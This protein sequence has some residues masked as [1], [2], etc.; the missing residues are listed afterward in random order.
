MSSKSQKLTSLALLLLF[1]TVTVSID[2]FHTDRGALRDTSCPVCHFQNSSIAIA[3]DVCIEMPDLVLLE[4]LDD[5]VFS[6]YK[7]FS[8]RSIAARSPPL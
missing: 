1:V 4:I 3:Q 2:L 5:L 7:A 6:E 8:S